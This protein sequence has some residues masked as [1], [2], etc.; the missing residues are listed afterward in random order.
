MPFI[1]YLVTLMLFFASPG[2]AE[3]PPAGTDARKAG[4]TSILPHQQNQSLD[5]SLDRELEQLAARI[6][7]LQNR[8]R[9]LRLQRK[10]YAAYSVKQAETLRGDAARQESLATVES[11]LEPYLNEVVRRL[12]NF[13][14][15][16]LPFLPEERSKRLAS[17]EQ[18]MADYHLNPAEKLRRILEAL[19]VEAGYG[20]STGIEQRFL[21]LHGKPTKVHLLRL[22]RV[23]L[24]YLTPD[25]Q[26]GGRYDRKTGRW[27][28]LSGDSVAEVKAALQMVDK[29]RTMQLVNLPVA[30]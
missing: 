6:H 21:D 29:T 23:A 15:A 8:L 7:S 16:D 11:Q 27:E 25:G 12:R 22:G 28:A 18:V 4:E 1:T 5:D 3:T 30:R 9:Q 17:L 19:Q 26:Q 10:K 24:Y 2:W 20:R 14:Q 13:V